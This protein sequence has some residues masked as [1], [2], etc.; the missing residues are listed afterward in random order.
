MHT[1]ITKETLIISPKLHPKQSLTGGHVSLGANTQKQ[2]SLRLL[3]PQGVWH[4]VPSAQETVAAD[5]RKAPNG[6]AEQ[7]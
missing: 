7:P 2:C 1:L 4:A 3:P 5:I 6:E